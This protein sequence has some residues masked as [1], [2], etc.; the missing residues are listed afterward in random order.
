METLRAI[1]VNATGEGCERLATLDLDLV[2]YMIEKE[3]KV[4]F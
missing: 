4:S 2:F 3:E 1:S